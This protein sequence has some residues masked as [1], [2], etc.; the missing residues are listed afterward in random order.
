MTYVHLSLVSSAFDPSNKNAK[1]VG[2]PICIHSTSS[3]YLAIG[4]TLANIALFEVGSRDYKVLKDTEMKQVIVGNPISVVMSEDS[5]WL[6]AGF[7]GGGIGLWDL[8][9]LSLVKTVPSI[10]AGSPTII[11]LL[12]WKGNTDFLS[13]DSA[14]NVILHTIEK[15]VWTSIRS[16]RLFSSAVT[17]YYD[18]KVNRLENGKIVLALA[19]VDFIFLIN[20]EPAIEIITKIGRPSNIS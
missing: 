3:K 4:T 7:E 12:F 8:A 6:V 13:L 20:L 11:K 2:L 18:A 14:G 17:P 19:N 16:R 10:V 1:G 15:Y 5:K 9:S